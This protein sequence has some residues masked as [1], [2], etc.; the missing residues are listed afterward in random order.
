MSGKTIFANM[1][2]NVQCDIS[3]HGLG[4]VLLQ[5]GQPIDYRSKILTTTDSRY[6]QI[7]KDFLLFVCFLWRSPLNT[8]LAGMRACNRTK[9][10]QKAT[11]Y[12]PDTPTNTYVRGDQ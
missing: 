12:C 4:A 11:T 7:E 2:T 8:L 1:E 3:Q 10:Y 9:H 6:A 5:D